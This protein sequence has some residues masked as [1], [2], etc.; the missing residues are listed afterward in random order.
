MTQPIEKSRAERLA[1]IAIVVAGLLVPALSLVPLGSLWLWQHGLLVYWAMATLACAS[2]AYIVQRRLFPAGPGAGATRDARA[3][4]TAE[5]DGKDLETAWSPLEEEAWRDVKSYARNAAPELLVTSEGFSR[6][7]REVVETVARRLHPEK[8]DPL[9]QFT[10]PEA[11]AIVERVSRRLRGF[12]IE[13]VPFGDRLTVAQALALY[14]WRGAFAYLERAYDLWRVVRLANPLT[15]VTQEAREYFSKAL[16]Q[17][18]REQISRRLAEAYLEEVGRAA[19]DLYGGRL[20]VALHDL[21]H[22]VSAETAADIATAGE[23]P[24]E[25]LRI[26]VVGQTGAGKSSLVNALAREVKAAVD[27]LPATASF[28]A[29]ALERD[30][31]PAALL[32]DSP[33]LGADQRETEAI[34]AKAADC[35]IVLWV[36][37]AHRADREIDRRGLEAFRRHFAVRLDRRPPPVILV[38]AHIDRLRPFDEWA[39]PYDLAGDRPKEVNIREA[40][41][42]AATDLGFSS[43]EAV[44]VSLREGSA[45]FNVEALWRRIAEALPEALRARLLRCLREIG[46]SWRWSKVWS[47]AGGAG[48]VLV[49]ALRKR[50]P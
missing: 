39:P 7:T 29:Y 10:P 33:G 35:D 38:A 30:G 14:R 1:R 28:N 49:S 8:A 25:P 17:W 42:S 20:R 24:A 41:A 5:A 36:V 18:G 44:A 31:L 15:A 12:M 32:I 45:P 23:A 4:E 34:V 47:Q 3:G 48:R 19:I 40:V 2:L 13:A 50:Q 43:K 6:L 16:L 11:L 22:Y 21:Q 9:W 37:A 46:R 27:S 26:L